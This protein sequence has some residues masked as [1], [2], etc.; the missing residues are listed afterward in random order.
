M[1]AA[2]PEFFSWRETPPELPAPMASS[3]IE[4]VEAKTSVIRMPF[5]EAARPQPDASHELGT[6]YHAKSHEICELPGSG[7]FWCT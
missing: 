3:T 7:P 5:A 6:V 1:S 4:K 2:P